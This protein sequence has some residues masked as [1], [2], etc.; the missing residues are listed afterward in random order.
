MKAWYQ[1]V[2]DPLS[3]PPNTTPSTWTEVEEYT[4]DQVYARN[5]VVVKENASGGP[6]TVRVDA[7]TTNAAHFY[8]DAAG[9]TRTVVD[10]LRCPP[11]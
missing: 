8:T 6:T 5:Q 10:G 4:L 7:Y 11:F 2:Q 1:G 3:E 9:E